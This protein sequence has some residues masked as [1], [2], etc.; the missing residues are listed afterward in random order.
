MFDEIIFRPVWHFYWFEA[1][2]MVIWHTSVMEKI[3]A[4]NGLIVQKLQR[5]SYQSNLGQIT[6]IWAK[7][8]YRLMAYF[9]HSMK[10]FNVPE[11]AQAFKIQNIA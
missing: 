8:F 10:L 5:G 9:V 6:L 2:I 3:G 1:L 11:V 7:I 4:L